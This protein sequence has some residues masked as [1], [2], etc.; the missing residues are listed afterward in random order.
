MKGFRCVP[1]AQWIVRWASNPKVVEPD[2]KL[3]SEPDEKLYSEPDQGYLQPDEIGNLI[4]EV[5]NL[6]R[7]INLEGDSDDVQELLL[8]I[9]ELIEMHEQEQDIYEL[10]SLEPVQSEDRMTPGKIKRALTLRHR[11]GGSLVALGLE[12][13]KRRHDHNHLCN[14]ATSCESSVAGFRPANQHR[15]EFGTLTSRLR[16]TK[17]PDKSDIFLDY[18][19][20]SLNPSLPLV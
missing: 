4:E 5:V 6:A 14:V 1:V 17:Y 3:Y 10:E 9:D 16:G 7:Q 15:H 11:Q 8:T 13:I 12:L 18:A 2:E 20:F 19:P